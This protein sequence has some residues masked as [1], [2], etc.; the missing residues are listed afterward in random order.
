MID[1]TPDEVDFRASVA[2]FVEEAIVPSAAALDERG[3]FPRELFRKIG[4]LEYFGLRY[5]ESVGG[6][7]AGFVT[8][9]LMAEELAR[10]S[11]SV[12]AMTAMQGMMATDFLFRHGTQDQ[13]DRFLRPALR[14]E[15]IGAFCLT[16]P[17][18]GSDLARIATAAKETPQGWRLGG[19]KFWVTNGTV[20]DFFTVAA[21]VDRSKGLK[22]LKFFLVERGAPGLV[23]G[24]KISTLGNRAG[25]TTELSLDDT[26]AAKLG[27]AGLEDLGKILDQIR[28]MTGALS[29]GLARA[30]LDEAVR[31][32]KERV[33]FG[34]PIAKLQAL[35]HMIAQSWADLEASRLAVYH[36]ARRIERAEKCGP[37]AAAAKLVASE[38]ANRVADAALRVLGGA[39]FAM[40]HAAQRYFR[41]AR[42]LLI[43]GGTSEILRNVIAKDVLGD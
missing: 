41:D 5:P 29:L 35:R 38:M 14:G 28:V 42:F 16:E 22:G 20:A 19:S 10:G 7:G 40:E 26:P 1:L 23:V 24:R 15:K 9:C 39:G 21:T 12:A 11:M 2:R 32:S 30:A 36:A 17:D 33:C 18:A 3:D 43:G 25:E 37:A 13:H 34:Q 6:S 27:D 8:Y 31:Y 4:R